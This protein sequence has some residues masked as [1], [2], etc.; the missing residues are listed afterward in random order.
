LKVPATVTIADGVAEASIVPE[1]GAGLARYDLMIDGRREPIFRPCREPSEGRPFDLALNLLVPWSNRISGGGFNFGSE[2]HRLEPNLPGERFPIHGNAF[3]CAWTIESRDSTWAALSLDSPGPGP[4]RY[5]ARVTYELRGGALAVSLMARNAGRK[6]L[7]FGLGLHPWLPRTAETRL[8]AKS[9]RVALEN[10]DHLPAGE[11]D[12]RAREDWNFATLRRLPQGWINNAFLGWNGRARVVWPDRRM[13]LE[14][15]AE[16][17]ISTYIVY[18]PG[19]E[20]DFFCFEPVTHPVDAHNLPGW[21]EAN[22]LIVLK[23]EQEMSISCRFAPSHPFS[24]GEKV[25]GP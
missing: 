9:D 1:L 6:A 14:I 21:A 19:A 17:P 12:V 3:S 15:S 13:A 23:P 2:F 10:S 4:F 7:P 5:A 24:L 25:D 20:A 8:E 11:L 18:S 16:P 22:G